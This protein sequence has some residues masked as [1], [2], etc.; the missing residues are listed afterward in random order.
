MDGIQPALCEKAL[1]VGVTETGSA[2]DLKKC[3][4]KAVAK[5]Q[6]IH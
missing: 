2:A 6:V 4:E 5:R 3:L 1:R